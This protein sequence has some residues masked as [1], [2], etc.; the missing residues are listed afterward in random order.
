MKRTGA[1]VLLLSLIALTTTVPVQQVFADTAQDRLQLGDVFELVS[2]RGIAYDRAADEP[3]TAEM[4]LKLT[5]TDVNGSRVRFKITSGE[6]TVGD[7][8]FAVTDGQG[9]ALLRK[10]GWATLQGDAKLANGKMF[11]L[12]LDGM[13]HIEKAGL[14]LTGLTGGLGNDA[15][16]IRLRLLM[17]LSRSQQ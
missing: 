17:R 11:K 8:A 9:R 6:I 16:Q 14:L 10:F 4:S 2:V 1:F 3:T 13:L 15:E 7:K 5:V 12:H